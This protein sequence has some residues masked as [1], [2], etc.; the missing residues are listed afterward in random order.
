MNRTDTGSAPVA[1]GTSPPPP[2]YPPRTTLH[3]GEIVVVQVVSLNTYYA[4]CI[5]LEYSHAPAR[6]LYSELSKRNFGGALSKLCKVGSRECCC[7]LSTSDPSGELNLSR[8]R[9]PREVQQQALQKYQKSRM[10]LRIMEDFVEEM[11]SKLKDRPQQKEQAPLGQGGAP[12]SHASAHPSTQSYTSSSA[13]DETT[14]QTSDLKVLRNY[15][16]QYFTNIVYPCHALY[17]HCWVAFKM[18]ITDSTK[19]ESIFATILNPQKP[20]WRDHTT[21]QLAHIKSVLFQCIKRRLKTRPTKMR[22]HIEVS[23]FSE[24]GIDNVKEALLKAQNCDSDIQVNLIAHPVFALTCFAEDVH[25]G[26]KLLIHAMQCVKAC[27]MQ[28]AHSKFKCLQPPNRVDSRMDNTLNIIM[29]QLESENKEVDGDHE[30]EEAI[31]FELV[32]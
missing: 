4:H 6:I 22:C 31:E 25:E 13:S 24:N 12:S 20:G 28:Y 7:V 2:F 8:K 26:R 19:R 18:C 27:I 16:Q 10:V 14:P 30:E 5:L 32:A 23:S 9:V 11:H 3:E 1:N 15:L 29:Q 21:N 17:G